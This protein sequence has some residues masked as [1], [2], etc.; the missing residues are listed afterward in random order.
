MVICHV[1]LNTNIQQNRPNGN[2]YGHLTTQSAVEA[3]YSLSTSVLMA[4]AAVPKK[5]V[6][7]NEDDGESRKCSTN[8]CVCTYGLIRG[9]LYM[10]LR[11]SENCGLQKVYKKIEVSKRT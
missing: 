4:M 9:Q 2:T 5:V 11:S 7:F 6:R 10:C 3:E 1:L 8:A